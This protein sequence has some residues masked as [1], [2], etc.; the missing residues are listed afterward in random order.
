ML[1]VARVTGN[2]EAGTFLNFVRFVR[3]KFIARCLSRAAEGITKS[4][5]RRER[6][7]R[8]ESG[9][10]N[11]NPG[12]VSFPEGG[13]KTQ[14]RKLLPVSCDSRTLTFLS[15]DALLLFPSCY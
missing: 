6:G 3:G 8:G 14:T 4:T 12:V 10:K 13:R 1:S 9:K 15:L 7:R 2:I 5:R 11:G